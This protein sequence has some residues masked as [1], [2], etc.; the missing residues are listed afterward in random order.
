MQAAAYAPTT[1]AG[2]LYSTTLATGAQAYWKAGYTGKGV[3]VAVVD[4]GT[5]PV[6][7]LDGTGKV[8]NGPDLSFESQAKG[9]RYLDTYGHGTHIA[10]IIAGRGPGAVAGGYAGDTTNVLGMAPDARIVSV[11]VAD[12][13]GAADVSQII[14]AIDWVV[15]NRNTGGLNIRVL[16]LSFGTNTANPYTID[17]LCHAVEAAWRKGITVVAATGN[18]GYYMTPSGPGLTSPARDPYVIAVGA[19]DA[20]KTL[21]TADDRVASFSSSGVVGTGGTKNPDLVAPGKSIISLAVP[22]SF[23]DQTYGATGSVTGGF[24]RGSGTSQA[25]AVMS[26]A[27]ALVRSTHE[28]PDGTGYPDGLSGDRIPLGSRIIAVCDAFTAMT[29][30]RPYAGQRTIPEA[31]AELRRG[32]GSQFDRAVV[33]ALSELVVEP[34]WP[35]RP[36]PPRGDHVPWALGGVAI[37]D[38]RRPGRRRRARMVPGG[39]PWYPT[40]TRGGAAPVTRTCRRGHAGKVGGHDQAAGRGGLRLLAR[41][42]QPAQLHEPPGVGGA[43]RRRALALDGQR[44]RRHDRRLGGRDR[45]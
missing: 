21:S 14:A 37:D 8:V 24:R 10:G 40:P 25:T 22:G 27:A 30:A 19:T 7:G 9:L 28:R 23:I 13:M 38:R 16:N 42:R 39:G 1:D 41:L 43:V 3:D 36:G 31:V 4:T 26:G 17:P 2:S 35:A 44:P 45:R 6:G 11:K 18:A 5:A 34:L 33:D 12:A 20:N 15:Q 32:A 29:S